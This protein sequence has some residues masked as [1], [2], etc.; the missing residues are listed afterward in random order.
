MARN[1]KS[2]KD[3]GSAFEQ[4]TADYLAGTLGMPIERRTNHGAKDC[5]DIAGVRVHGNDVVVECKSVSSP[6]LWRILDEAEAERR[7]A[8]VQLGIAVLKVPGCGRASMERQ[9]VAMDWGMWEE[10]ASI[11]GRVVLW[12]SRALWKPSRM[13]A[14]ADGRVWRVS[15][16]G[17]GIREAAV[18][19][20]GKWAGIAEG[21]R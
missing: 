10:M 11:C 7:N 4:W 15:K 8:G 21:E 17:E 18:M 20:L 1:R 9:L 6:N 16:Q 14:F 12:E 3:A 2:A 19:T 13:Q 5:G